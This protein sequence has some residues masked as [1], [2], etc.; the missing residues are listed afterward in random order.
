MSAAIKGK[1]VLW[2]VA[3]GA[4]SA[5]NVAVTGGIITS[6]EIDS[7]GGTTTVGDEDDDIVTRI[8]HAAENKIT[9]EVDCVAATTKPAKGTELTGLSTIDGVTFGT[10]R[11]FVDSSK[12][13]YARN[14]VKK[15][16]VSATHYPGMAADA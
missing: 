1:Q 7:Q 6:F 2:G 3:A 4:I 12:V 16:S 9:M 5:A 13:V 10:G 11:T 8:D 15:I 14:G